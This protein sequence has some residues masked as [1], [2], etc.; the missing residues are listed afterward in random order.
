M[1]TF[2]A[3]ELA[4]LREADAEIEAEGDGIF[5]VAWVSK[6]LDQ[7]SAEDL[8]D[9]RQLAQKKKKKAYYEAH[10]DEIAEKMKAYREAHKDEIREYMR[11]YQRE[12]RKGNR[13]RINIFERSGGREQC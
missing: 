11:T 5:E 8:L 1:A 13:R 12:Y 9:H 6:W 2:T 10:K 3:E 7:L 4:L